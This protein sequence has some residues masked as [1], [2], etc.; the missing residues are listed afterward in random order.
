MATVLDLDLDL[1]WVGGRRCDPFAGFPAGVSAPAAVH[2][3]GA[4]AGRKARPAAVRQ[5]LAGAAQ[6]Q[7]P[8][9]QDRVLRLR[10][11]KQ[12]KRTNQPI[13]EPNLT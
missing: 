6:T 3:E 10:S 8:H 12:L 1:D 4:S 11:R 13:K 2:L 7:S 5:L 9:Q